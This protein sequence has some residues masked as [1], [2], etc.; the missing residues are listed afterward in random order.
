MRFKFNGIIKCSLR[1]SVEAEIQLK[2]AYVC[3]DRGEVGR[4]KKFT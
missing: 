2:I 4:S 1:D 3:W